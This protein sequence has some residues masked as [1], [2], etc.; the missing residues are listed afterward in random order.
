[1]DRAPHA[2]RRKNKTSRLGEAKQS[3]T[4]DSDRIHQLEAEIEALRQTIKDLQKNNVEHAHAEETLHQRT[5]TLA[6]SDEELQRQ[7]EELITAEDELQQ[8]NEALRR[9][10][11]DLQVNEERLRSVLDSTRDVIVRFNL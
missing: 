3:D 7:N 1:M 5:E 8:N 2:S 6:A 11:Q 10:Q 4:S 9:I